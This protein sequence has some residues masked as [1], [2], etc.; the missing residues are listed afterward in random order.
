MYVRIEQKYEDRRRHIPSSSYH[1][2]EL[3]VLSSLFGGPFYS[4]AHPKS[5]IL[6]FEATI[7]GRAVNGGASALRLF[8]LGFGLRG[9]GLK[10]VRFGV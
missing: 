8:A 5:S 2:L 9:L 6:Y 7:S 3:P 4:G 10:K 1:I